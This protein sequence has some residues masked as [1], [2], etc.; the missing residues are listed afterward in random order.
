MD[1]SNIQDKIGL[2]GNTLW[3]RE[4]QKIKLNL[5]LMTIQ[6]QTWLQMK[7]KKNR[8]KNE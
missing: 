7:N 5:M 2:N 4:Q 3:K 1:L 6:Q 8:V